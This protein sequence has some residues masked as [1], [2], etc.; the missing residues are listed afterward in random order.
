MQ[1]G[2]S[3]RA[4]SN[5]L[6]QPLPYLLSAS[7]YLIVN[8]QAG[9]FIGMGAM[10][11]MVVSCSAQLYMMDMFG[12]QGAAS[13]LA[14]LTLVRN[15]SRVSLPLAAEPLYKRLGFRLGK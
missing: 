5:H 14:G 10:V 7:I 12:P 11:A 13:A 4:F 3:S 8:I 15:A 1:I 6:L 2:S 9:V